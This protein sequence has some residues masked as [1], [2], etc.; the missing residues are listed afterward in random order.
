MSTKPK[1]TLFI[2]GVGLLLISSL[3]ARLPSPWQWLAAVPF[4][5]SLVFGVRYYLQVKRWQPTVEK[6]DA[7]EV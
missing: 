1:E 4:A 5:S 2:A 7:P 6:R 3:I